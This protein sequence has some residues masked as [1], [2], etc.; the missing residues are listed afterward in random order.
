MSGTKSTPNGTGCLAVVGTAGRGNDAIFLNR[1]VYIRMVSA[2]VKFIESLGDLNRIRLVSGGAAWTDHIVITM[3]LQ[4]IVRPEN[5]T[6]FAPSKFVEGEY[7]GTGYAERTSR[8]A[9]HYH[10]EFSKAVGG[11]TLT[12]IETAIHMGIHF[13]PGSGDFKARNT[14]VARFVSPGG[15]LLAF[16]MGSNTSRQKPMTIHTFGMDDDAIVGGLKDGGTADTWNKSKC[17]KHHARL[18]ICL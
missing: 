16:T 15:H 7:Y 18:G 13:I 12:E 1:D 8:T 5:V 4:R 6:V 11:N 14:Q 3:V 17:V 2:T 9:N 10:R